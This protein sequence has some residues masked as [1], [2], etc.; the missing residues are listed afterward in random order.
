MTRPSH[1]SWLDHSNYTWRRVQ[2]VKL[3]IMQ[4]SPI[5][6]RFVPLWFWASF[7]R[8][9]MYVFSIVWYSSD[10]YFQELFHCLKSGEIWECKGISDVSVF[11]HK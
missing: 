1:P 2:V 5:S 8:S 3:L 7:S 10:D 6:C 4:F 11:F 9:K